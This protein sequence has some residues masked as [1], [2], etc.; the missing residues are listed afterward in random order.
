MP[1]QLRKIR[2]ES[3]VFRLPWRDEPEDEA[4][5]N[6][7]FKL[8]LFIPPDFLSHND[9]KTHKHLVILTN[10]LGEYDESIYTGPDGFCKRLRKEG[11][12]SVFLPVP[13]C[14]E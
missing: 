14:F 9:K 7:K 6:N 8:K 5:N 1:A 12:A 11:V 13:K 4:E 10:G 3:E 2:I